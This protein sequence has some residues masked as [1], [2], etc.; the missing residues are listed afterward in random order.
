M[1]T[2]EQ[3]PLQ[4]RYYEVIFGTETTAGK[5]FDLVLI[6]IIITSVMVVLLDSIADYHRDYGALFLRIEWVFTALFTVE[7][8][9]RLW[10]VPNRK[11][12]ATS[13]YGV[14]DLL[15]LLPTY[16]SLLLPQTAPLLIIRLL[17]IL[18]IFRVLRLLA[19]LN[20]ANDL[21]G[22]LHR[23]TRKIFVFFSLMIILA[24]I[25]GCLIYVIEGP[26]HGFNNIPHSIYWA[27][28]TITTV[29]YGDVT[30]QTPL[31]QILSSVGM[32]I[33]Y[34]VI[35][36][37]T[38]IVTAEMTRGQMR[39]RADRL[40]NLRNCT[41]CAA[42]E[43]DPTAHY[44]RRCGSHLPAPGHAPETQLRSEDEAGE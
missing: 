22:A 35:A 26:E 28:V 31:G 44:C 30:P 17:R 27:I 6:A 23:S 24:T 12:Y 39:E 38:G 16:L 40:R 2:R 19:L 14:V 1:S 37:P 4:R 21:A 36:V 20:E 41:T 9:V 29:G 7:Y 32:L 42:A 15:A 25:F 5:W 18:R 34:A 13:I 33:G 11:G 43:T 10:C 8:L 3:T